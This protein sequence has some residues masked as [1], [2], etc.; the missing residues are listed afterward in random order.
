MYF[1]HLP[2][3]E[4]VEISRLKASV[5][6]KLEETQIIQTVLDTEEPILGKGEIASF[7]NVLLFQ[8]CFQK[9]SF[10]SPSKVGTLW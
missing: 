8:I 2:H 9:H 5:D 10:S 6:H 3:Y 7:Q 1:N 4:N